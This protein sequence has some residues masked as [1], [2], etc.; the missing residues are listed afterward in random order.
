MKIQAGYKTDGGVTM[1][2][3]TILHNVTVAPG[4][5]NAAVAVSTRTKE[6]VPTQ[7]LRLCSFVKVCSSSG[8]GKQSKDYDVRSKTFLITFELNRAFQFYWTSSNKVNN[9]DLSKIR[10]RCLL[11]RR[12]TLHGGVDYTF[13]VKVFAKAGENEV[14]NTGSIGEGQIMITVKS[15]GVNAK[16]SS[17]Y[18]KAGIESRVS[19]S[20][21]RS[22]NLD[23]DGGKLQVK[24]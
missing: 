15:R 4:S 21:R 3:K 14:A 11:L 7:N 10:S 5:E 22:R 20:G 19:I 23:F 12:G 16:L 13:E 24:S 1:L 2:D 18:I 6:I 17:E 8:K 9:M